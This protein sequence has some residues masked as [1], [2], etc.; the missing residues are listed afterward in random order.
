MTENILS[1]SSHNI[2]GFNSGK[3]FLYNQCEKQKNIV[4]CVQEHWL[5]P[6]YKKQPGVNKLRT[7]HPSFDG[8]GTS[9]MKSSLEKGIRRGRGFGGTGFVYPKNFTHILKPLVKFNHERISVLELECEGSNIIIINVYMP[10]LDRSN[11]QNAVIEYTS[12]LG[13]ID[14]IFS[15]MNHARFILLGDFNCDITDKYHP[16]YP[17]L[18]SFINKHDMMSSFEKC[19]TFQPG[20]S[21]TRFDARSRSLL[22]FIFI[23][24]GL[25]SSVM[26]VKIGDYHDNLSDH[27]PVELELSV[28][29]AS[30]RP[31]NAQRPH[32]QIIWS[33]LSNA[34]L[35][36]FS[37]TMELA[38]DLISIPQC[39]VHGNCMCFNGE[40][41]LQIEHY[42]SKLLEAI[43]L[44]DA[45]LP[46]SCFRALKPFWTK[47]LSACKSKSVHSHRKWLEQNKPMHGPVYD[48][49]IKCRAEYR[50]L[51]RNEKRG[52]EISQNDK[53]YKSL[54]DKNQVKFWQTWKSMS[55]VNEPPSTRIDG[56]TTDDDIAS[57]FSTVF[58]GIYTDNDADA[59]ISLK[60]EFDNLFPSYFMSHV[61]DDISFYY[62]TWTDMVDMVRKLK[63]GKSY[64]GF[65]K[66]E[67]IL[68]GSPKLMF[69][70]HI[71]FNAMLQHGY[72]PS[73]FLRG[74]M[75]PLVKNRDGDTT[76]SG[77]YRGIT[78][79]PIFMQMYEALEKKKFG[80]F[81]TSNDRQFGFKPGVSASHAIFTLKKTTDYFTNNGS[82]AYLAFLDCSKAFDR[83]SHWGLFI[84][85]MKRNVPLCF[86]LSVIFLYLNM[87][88]TVKWGTKHSRSFDIPSGTKQ[89]G[90]LSPD[91]FSLYVNDL[92]DLLVDS[93]FGCHIIN[94][95]I[96]CLFFADDIVLLSPS[97]HG[98]QKLL[99]IA[100]AYCK[101]FCL[102]FNVS[103]SK[104]MVIG[105]DLSSTDF[106]PLRI[107]DR[108]LD[109]VHAFKYLGVHLVDGKELSFSAIPELLSFYRASNALINGRVKPK[110][111]ILMKLLY[112]NCVSIFTYSAAVKE[113]TSAE[114]H[115][116]NVAIN[117]GIRKIYTYSHSESVRHLRQDCNLKSIYELFHAARSKFDDDSI[118]SSNKIVRYIA[119]CD[120]N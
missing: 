79:S 2:R 42:F 71:V 75:T 25:A 98:L 22:D 6:A 33:K 27:L 58:S 77:N 32:D 76:D 95:V 49:Y 9:A 56:H 93:G 83:I 67:H 8:F 18:N 96:T 17:L 115:D 5:P 106:T 41:M 57:C 13:Y 68:H 38:L 24:R 36:R 89:G 78:L 90:I 64:A 116:I 16:F 21:F 11:L 100:S 111:E 15:E 31:P 110:N 19:D 103:K 112:S 74:H 91:F 54:V 88:C 39:V 119:H 23:S 30:P 109:F 73:Y 113:F 80:Y 69:H 99:D 46:R 105:R 28:S 51:L 45:T 53:L 118:T 40:H 81:L 72:I 52:K 108:D 62:Y 102:D 7:V 14:Y 48:T 114:M 101:Q 1:I 63:T 104:V 86:L 61:H 37:T 43:E 3:E 34:D 59:H 65:V 60:N 84:K 4:Q 87:S 92:I 44:A 107:D 29:F 12:T 117:N 97:R 55:Q 66:A 47:E 85:L 82:R 50:G 94:M 35:D 70:L 20:T 10:F 120:F 26:T